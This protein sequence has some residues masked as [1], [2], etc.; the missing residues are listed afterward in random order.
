MSRKGENKKND[1]PNDRD[2]VLPKKKKARFNTVSTN[3]EIEEISKGY[4]PV[5]TK[6][7]TSWSMKVFS[8]WRSA[9]DGDEK[10]PSDLFENPTTGYWLPRFINEVRRTD[11]EPYPPR[12]INQILAGLQRYMLDN[13]YCVPKFLDWK[14]SQ[15]RPIHGA[16][17]YVYHTLHSQGVGTSVQS[18][19]VITDDEEAQLWST[20]VLGTEQPLQLLRAVFYYVG[21]RFCVRGGEE[22]R[23][24]GPS[25]FIRSHNP[26][27][28]TFV[29][30]GSKNRSGTSNELHLKNKVVPCP[31]LPEER[32]QCLVFLMDLYLSKLPKFAFDAD[33]LYLRPK[34]KAS[35][36][37][38]EAWFDNA[39]V[40]KNKLA[41]IVKDMCAEAGI[42][43]KTNHSLR[44]TGATTMFQNSVP[45][46]V[47]QKVTGHR[48]LEA[49][50]EYERVSI[51][52]HKQ[53]SKI[54]MTN[55]KKTESVSAS[56]TKVGFLGGISNL[57]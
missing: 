35:S 30:H 42:A 16:C 47:I 52:Q 1:D 12:T 48:S 34:R 40:G 33:I 15:F 20:G 11:G 50:R 49:L 32:P 21:K 19:P 27:C 53:V 51:D 14:N 43:R 28:F 17:D 36:D 55:V 56:E 57:L 23:K 24:L 4:V 45:E 46:R 22:Q 2:F 38:N 44:A 37:L 9:R 7:N 13:N 3:S 18:T 31:A 5:N 29:E 41:T 6:R 54:L 26:D 39:A 25:Q 8:E 10:C